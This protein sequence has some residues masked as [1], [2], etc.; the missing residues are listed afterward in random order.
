[1]SQE[2][3]ASSKNRKA[4]FPGNRG[5]VA[6]MM[7]VC[8]PLLLVTVGLGIEA[9]GWVVNQQ[10]W[11]QR[12]AD[13]AAIAGALAYNTGVSSQTAVTEAAYVA[14][15][16]I[17]G[18]AARAGGTRSWSGQTLTDNVVANSVITTGIVSGVKA[19][20]DVAVSA[21]IQY[22][23]PLF[24]SALAM[25]ETNA[26]LTLSATAT[27]ENVPGQTGSSCVLALDG[28]TSTGASTSGTEFENGATVDLSQCGIHVNALG[29]DALYLT[30]GATLKANS[31][32]VSGN[33][34]VNNGAIM[35]VTGATTTGA[36]PGVN[37]YASVAIPT[38]ATCTSSNTNLSFIAG[39][40]IPAG[41]Y[42]NGL[43]VNYGTV[44]MGPGVVIIDGGDFHPTGGSTVNAANGTTIVLTGSSGSNV[45]TSQIDNGVTVNLVAP[46]TGPTAGIAIIQDP[47]AGTATSKMA[48]GASVNITGALV[49][50]SS[51]VDFS[52][53]STNNSVC[54]ELVAFQ[55]V[56]TGGAKFGN[57]CAGT[58][59]SGIDATTTTS[60]VQ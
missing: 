42:C 33:Y 53:G 31:V 6:V 1:M 38:P 16:N 8:A 37:P 23:V 60:L 48:G 27:A 2:V 4:A 56:F 43:T 19:A 9:S 5:T 55:I 44:T 39:Q 40:N 18:A 29:P 3:F 13:M 26:S 36:T 21:Q 58:G 47:R 52:N 20:S 50:P 22:T 25:K 51:V 49:F 10:G 11:M 24:L 30:G 7:A 32:K 28:S 46:T 34:S 57:N 45:G 15:V 54:T 12:T 41:T 17:P 35:T 59:T 14:E